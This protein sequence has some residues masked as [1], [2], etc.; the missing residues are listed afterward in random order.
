MKPLTIVVSFDV[1][2]QVVPGGIPGFVA[3]L[4]NEFGFDRAKAAFHWRVIPAISLPAHGLDHPGCIEDL[5]VTGGG[6]LAAAIG[7]VN[8][9]WRRL[10][11]L[12]G[13]RQGRD[14]QFR[15]HVVT[16]RPANDLPREKIKHDSQI[17][18]TFGGWHIAYIGEPDLI[19][20]NPYLGDLPDM[21]M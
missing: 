1:G 7:M 11:A 12:D 21:K 8:E 17:E 18:P 20:G 6:V 10:L 19:G 13:H 9:A 5:A 2:E 4:V 16:H 15:P 3:S 14:G